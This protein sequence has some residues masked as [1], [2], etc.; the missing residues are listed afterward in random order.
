M[1]AC[2]DSASD[3]LGA[4][5]IV[6]QCSY[7]GM[8]HFEQYIHVVV[9]GAPAKSVAKYESA[10]AA[11]GSMERLRDLHYDPASGQFRD[12]GL[13]T[14]DVEL[15]W[16]ETPQPNGH[17]PKVKVVQGKGSA[18]GAA[19]WSAAGSHCDIESSWLCTKNCTRRCQPRQPAC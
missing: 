15:V 18:D 3:I 4:I 17:Q 8:M 11:I 6:G 7:A 1:P 10:A 5:L 16:R 9:A 13:H 14:E 12:Y 19:Y 2:T